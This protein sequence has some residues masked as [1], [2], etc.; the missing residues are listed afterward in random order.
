VATYLT[1]TGKQY[2]ACTMVCSPT[3]GSCHPYWMN[4]S[5]CAAGAAAGDT[6][7]GGTNWATAQ[8]TT[9]TCEYNSAEDTYAVIGTITVSCAAVDVIRA[10]SYWMS[11]SGNSA[12]LFISG[13][14]TTIAGLAAP[15][16]VQYT[17]TL[18]F[19]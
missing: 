13:D 16:Q 18:Q 4:M 10:G 14:H 1:T 12:G 15:D 19:T 6:G 5:S 9:A 8:R 7:I 11:S 2:L 3:V 17:I